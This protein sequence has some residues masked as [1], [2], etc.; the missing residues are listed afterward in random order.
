MNPSLLIVV[1]M[2][3]MVAEIFVPSFGILGVIGLLGF[4]V[5][6]Y[7]LLQTLGPAEREAVLYMV[8]P[9][10]LLLLGIFGAIGAVLYKSR[11]TLF[12]KGKLAPVGE[13]AEASDDFNGREGMIRIDGELWSAE[14]TD[15]KSVKRGDKLLV[16]ARNGLKLTVQIVHKI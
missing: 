15:D 1:A 2:V 5:G 14:L 4:V 10:F 12:K 16:L 11:R 3:L 8:V 7:E 13:V 6:F 9:S